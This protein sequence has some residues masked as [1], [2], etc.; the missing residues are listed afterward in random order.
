MENKGGKGSEERETIG[1]DRE[2]KG[3]KELLRG[4]GEGRKKVKSG[5]WGRREVKIGDGSEKK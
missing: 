2:E 3:S 1:E 5:K 4:S